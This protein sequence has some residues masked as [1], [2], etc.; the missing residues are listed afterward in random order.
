MATL[1]PVL[2]NYQN[3]NKNIEKKMAFMINTQNSKWRA[4]LWK[5]NNNNDIVVVVT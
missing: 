5:K 3:K 4:M 2:F 1:N